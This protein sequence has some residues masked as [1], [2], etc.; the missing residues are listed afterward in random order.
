M[1]G[2]VSADIGRT[3]E[4]VIRVNSQSSKGGIAY[5]LQADHG[6]DLPYR[7][8]MDFARG[9]QTRTEQGGAQIDPA[10]VL[11]LLKMAIRGRTVRYRHTGADGSAAI[12]LVVDRCVH[13]ATHHCIGPVEALIRTPAEAGRRVDILS[14]TQQSIGATAVSYLEHRTGWTRGPGDSVLGASMSAVLHAVNAT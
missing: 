11:E 1:A 13:A 2:A 9:V 7:V 3:D 14:L 5:L 6:L 10:E 8:Q 12:T 4:A